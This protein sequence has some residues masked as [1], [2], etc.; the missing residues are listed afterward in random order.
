MT[1]TASI[2]WK[3][4]IKRDLRKEVLIIIPHTYYF[5]CQVH[6]V[7]LGVS[8]NVAYTRNCNGGRDIE[9]E[10]LA[11]FRG[12]KVSAALAQVANRPGIVDQNRFL[13]R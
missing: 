2:V 11:D 6:R 10:V 4:L 3:S 5:G 7:Q 12:L 1:A 13:V 9:G 8:H